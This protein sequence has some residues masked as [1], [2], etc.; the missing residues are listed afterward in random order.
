MRLIPIL[1]GWG[2]FLIQPLAAR[3]HPVA[4]EGSTGIMG[5]HS[6]HMTD[7]ELNY[8]VR[9][10]IA[11]SL[12]LFRFTEGT[13]RPDVLLG[14]V[15][16]LAKRWNGYDYQ[17]NIYLHAGGGV[18]RLFGERRGVYHLGATADIENRRL[19]LSG[20]ADTLRD[21][22]GTQTFFW[23]VRGGFAPYVADFSGLHTWLVLEAR[24][25]TLRNEHRRVEVIPTLRFF[26]QNVL[27]EVGS[28]LSGD[29]YFN[30]IIHI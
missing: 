6:R 21:G 15:N 5:Y 26:Y 18:S 8:S 20:E 17:A 12:Q 4:F 19:Y 23:K 2:L 13:N 7:L 11:P 14:K 22:D 1:I 3:A 30:Y 16:F 27:W 29:V 24:R 25:M 28:S 10:W 9:S